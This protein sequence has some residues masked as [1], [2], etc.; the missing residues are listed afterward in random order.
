MFVI[1][2]SKKVIHS[3]N[4]LA[5][6]NCLCLQLKPN[7]F[8]SSIIATLISTHVIS[9][10]FPCKSALTSKRQGSKIMIVSP[11]RRLDEADV[12]FEPATD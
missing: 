8:S 11:T 6:Y 1:G 12:G 2:K 4:L 9:S 10:Q 5:K 3:F 7:V